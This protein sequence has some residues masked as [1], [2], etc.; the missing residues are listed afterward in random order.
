MLLV[1]ELFP[2]LICQ[3]AW[4]VDRHWMWRENRSLKRRLTNAKLRDRQASTEAIDS[5]RPRGLDRS[6]ILSLANCD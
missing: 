4:L 3:L 1:C 2:A 6:L 5:R